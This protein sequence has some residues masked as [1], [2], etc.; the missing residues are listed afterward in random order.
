MQ[1]L[2]WIIISAL[3]LLAMTVLPALANGKP[4]TIYL[5]YLPEFSNAGMTDA[6]GTA[7]VSI[8]EAWVEIKADGMPA[9]NGEQYE[10]W[11]QDGETGN[12]LSLGKFN[13]DAT[14]HVDY[15][16]ELDFIPEADYRYFLITIESDP[17][18]SPS[19]DARV[20]IAG[21]F[22]TAELLVVNTTPTPSAG[23]VSGGDGTGV[24]TGTNGSEVSPPLVEGSN[25]E[26]I[27]AHPPATLPVTGQ[28]SQMPTSVFALLAIGILALVIGGFSLKRLKS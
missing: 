22:P 8:G 27:V 28:E 18:A 16:N 10:A 20:S 4:I 17:D 26:T 6:S 11:I 9:L 3:A 19:A 13:A 25:G 1:R 15:Y 5:N 24:L 23:G 2:K 14:G 12:R 7:R 21:V